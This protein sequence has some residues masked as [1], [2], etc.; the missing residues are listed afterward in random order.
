M[1]QASDDSCELQMNDEQVSS[2][3]T[4]A[5]QIS[6]TVVLE[7]PGAQLQLQKQK[8]TMQI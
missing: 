8:R 5:G 2:T 7:L 1:E 3:N 6:A 4:N